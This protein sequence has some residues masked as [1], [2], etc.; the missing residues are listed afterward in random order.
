M[1]LFLQ[2]NLGRGVCPPGLASLVHASGIGVSMVW[3]VR[4]ECCADPFDGRFRRKKHRAEYE[5]MRLMH[6]KLDCRLPGP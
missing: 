1:F 6:L 4:V 3:M 2:C 5:S